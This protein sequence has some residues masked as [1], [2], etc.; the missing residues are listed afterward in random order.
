[1]IGLRS[2]VAQYDIIILIDIIETDYNYAVKYTSHY[3]AFIVYRR[4]LDDFV[5][6]LD[7]A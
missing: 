3:K 2:A 4:V 7:R 5:I 1:M 6:A